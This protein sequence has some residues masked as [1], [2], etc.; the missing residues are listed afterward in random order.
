MRKLLSLKSLVF[1]MIL[2]IIPLSGDA[3]TVN[4]NGPLQKW[5]RID[6]SLTLPG[7]NVSESA[8]TFRNTRMDVVFTSPSGRNIRVPGFFA[9]DGNAANTN[10]TQGRIYKAYL[11]PDETGNWTYRVLYYTGNNVSISNVGNLPNP[12]H[13]LTGNVGAI[14]PSNKSIPDLR[15]KGRLQYQRTGTNNQRRYL[16]FAETGQYFL[17]FGPDSPENFLDFSGFDFDGSRNGCNLCSEHSYNPHSND[18]NTGDPTWDGG[19]GRNIIGAVN[20]LSETGQ[21]NSLSMSLFGGDDKNVFPWT[22][23]NS[24]FI[25]DVSKLEQWEIVLNHAEQKGLLLHFKLAEAENWR[26]LNTQEINVYYREMVARFGHHLAVEWNISEEYGGGSSDGTAASAVPRINFLASVDPWNNHR[27]IH[28]RPEDEFK[29]KYDDFLAQNPKTELTGAS[30][31]NERS[32]AYAEV[33][34]LTRDLI[35]KSRNNNTPWVIASDE[36]AFASNGVFTNGNVNNQN[37]DPNGRKGVLWGNLMAGGGGVMWYGGSNGDFRT[38]DFRRYVNIDAW[39]RHAINDFFLGQNIEFWKMDN[40]DNLVSGNNNHCLAEAGQAYVVYLPNGGSTTLN[41][42]GQTGTFEVKWFDPRNGGALQNGSVT[43]VSGGGN[44]SLGNPPNNTG[45]DWAILVSAPTGTDPVTGVVV[46]P[47]TVAIS[48]GQTTSLVATISPGSAANKSV[49]W[50]SN[51]TSVATV[52]ANGV[53]AGISQG[54]AVITA[55]TVDGG[56]TASSTITVAASSVITLN[57]IND[58]YLQGTTRFNTNDLRVESGNRI[59]YLMFDL[60]AVTVPIVSAELTLSVSSDPGNGTITIEQGNTNNWNETNLSD[61]NK[62]NASGQLGTLNTTYAADQSYTWT[63]DS[64]QISGGGTL[65]LIVA[66][67][68][69][70]DVSFA[71]KEN[72]NAGIPVLTITTSGGSGNV[73]VTGVNVSPGTVTV[74]VGQN[75]TLTA[76]VTPANATNRSITWSSNN[77]AVATVNSNGV[78]TGVSNGT[79]VITATTADGGFTDTTTITVNTAPTGGGCSDA[80]YEE[81]NGL[82]VMEAENLSTGNSDWE[83]RTDKTGFTGAGYLEWTGNDFFNGDVAGTAGVI[84]TKIRINTPGTYR[85]EWR[86]SIARGSSTTDLNDS[87]LRF[88]DADDFYGEKPDGSRT[89]PRGEAR[90]RSPFPAGQSGNGYFKLYVNNLNWSFQSTTGDSADGRPVFVQFDNPGIYTMEIAARSEG[91]IIDRI[92]LHRGVA[93]PLALS[94]TETPCTGSPTNPPTTAISI[95]GTI[96]VE[97][98]VTNFGQVRVE[99]TPGTNGGQNLGFIQNND[100]TEYDINVATTGTYTLN[101]FVSSNGVGGAIIPS[102]N[103]ANLGRLDVSVNNAWHAYNVVT[104]TI[105][106]TQGIQRLR[107]TYSGP[108]GFLFNVERTELILNSTSPSPPTG[109]GTLI[110]EAEDFIATGGTFDDAFAGGPGLGVNRVATNINY[111]NNEDWAEYTINVATAGTYT[112]EYLISTPSDGAQI[113]LLVDGVLATTTDVP[114]NGDW[115]SFTALSGG[116]LTLSAGT[117]TVRIF[118]S[119]ATTW[120]WN[121]DRITLTTGSLTRDSGVTDITTFLYPNPSN[122]MFTIHGLDRNVEYIV[123]MYDIKGTKHLEKELTTDHTVNVENL[124]NGIYFLTISSLNGETNLQL[125]AIKN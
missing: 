23:V 53:V 27:V 50:S 43:S 51:N 94:N 44:R 13:N 95:P 19:K 68:G 45:N 90:G 54:T 100:Y 79:A 31:Q 113:Q 34:E 5:H 70:N 76:S 83:L 37:V 73:S 74:A 41:L 67:T 124:S 14:S 114:N 47:A 30:M 71:S 39:G 96:Q 59:A 120:Q 109:S 2:S 6:V 89:Y 29:E 98:F 16:R 66:A 3:Q 108:A 87:W 102:I 97:N 21:V 106:L 62:P 105:N 65:S 25:F 35:I 117:H 101:A 33:F 1:L 17:K 72:T 110:I 107:F 58:A 81:V 48:Q 116:T 86:N 91:H 104:T 7:G 88:P 115:D 36:Q 111:V 84:T 69:G 57:P 64:S 20:Y 121:L 119:S 11:R 26:A 75:N 22:L 4:V 28:T 82:V 99:D 42:A 93:T 46:T 12:V 112:I 9:A 49:N 61:G 40:N 52:N 118:A 77:T 56:F 125:K 63:L 78:V 32:N 8:N 60:S 55:T 10:A 103:G 85:F 123:R 15:A 80:D 18:F 92:V 122:D 24:R 38:E